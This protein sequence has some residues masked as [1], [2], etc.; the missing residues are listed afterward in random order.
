MY[1]YE[2]VIRLKDIDAAGLIYFANVF[3]L[4]HECYEA[5]LDGHISLGKLLEE[6]EY[7]APIVHADADIKLPIRLSD[8]IAIEMNLA[9]TSNSSYELQ[10]RLIN[11]KKQPAAIVK[12]IHVVLDRQ[13]GEP[14]KIPEQFRQMLQQV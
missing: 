3:T 9:K 2:T 12:T 11:E 5:F 10:Y 6:S 1:R 7:M 14:V 4:A 8:K 13:S